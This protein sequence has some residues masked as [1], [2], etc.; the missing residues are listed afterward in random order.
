MGIHVDL[1]RAP[2]CDDGNVA[3]EMPLN[4]PNV[5]SRRTPKASAQAKAQCVADIRSL[6]RIGRAFSIATLIVWAIAIALVR[7]TAP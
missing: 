1:V 6:D 5:A 4:E 2:T 3:L 7:S